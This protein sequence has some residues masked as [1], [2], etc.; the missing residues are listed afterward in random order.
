M[1]VCLL[2]LLKDGVALISVIIIIYLMQVI[3]KALIPVN[4]FYLIQVIASEQEFG[5]KGLFLLQSDGLFDLELC[6][7]H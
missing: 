7:C 6:Y 2:S 4:I 1:K 3:L 5:L